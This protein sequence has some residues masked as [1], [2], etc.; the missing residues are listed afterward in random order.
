MTT[1]IN[2][3]VLNDVNEPANWSAV[4]RALLAAVVGKLP[5]AGATV[6]ATSRHSHAVLVSANALVDPAVSVDNNG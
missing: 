1:A 5:N 3:Y 4:E 2:D 6:T